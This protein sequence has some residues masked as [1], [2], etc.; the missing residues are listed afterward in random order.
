[1][2]TAQTRMYCSTVRRRK[3]MDV[4]SIRMMLTPMLAVDEPSFVVLWTIGLTSRR[5]TSHSMVW[6]TPLRTQIAVKV[7]RPRPIVLYVRSRYYT[8]TCSGL[9]FLASAL[10]TS[11]HVRTYI[12]FL[13]SIRVPLSTHAADSDANLPHLIWIH[14][15]AL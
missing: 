7:A 12:P 9:S 4:Q 8:Y 6:L 13:S 15:Q 2:V 14:C 5:N 1:M 10:L 3:K 11:Q